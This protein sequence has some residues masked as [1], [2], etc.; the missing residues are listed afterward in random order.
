MYYVLNHAN[1]TFAGFTFPEQVGTEID[2]LLT[3][4]NQISEN[5]IEI[6]NA[7]DE[8]CRMSVDE[9]RKNWM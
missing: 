5:E 3:T 6:I 8:S 9:F 7:S 2:R 1:H 4:E